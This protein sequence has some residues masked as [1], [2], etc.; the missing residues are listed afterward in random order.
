MTTALI[1]TGKE[2]NLEETF[3]KYESE[4]CADRL[5]MALADVAKVRAHTPKVAICLRV[6]RDPFPKEEMCVSQLVH[7]TLTE[8]SNSTD[9]EAFTNVITSFK[10]SDIKILIS[11]R[12]KTLFRDDA[13]DILKNVMKKFTELITDDL[14]SWIACHR[15][16]QSS[17]VQN[18]VVREESFKYLTSFATQTVLEKAL[19]ILEKNEHYKAD[20]F[21]VCCE[22]HNCFPHDLLDKLNTLLHLV[23]AGNALTKDTLAFLPLV[24]VDMFLDYIRSSTD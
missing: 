24:L 18:R 15:F 13:V 20:L 16:D 1:T 9:T 7:R 3:K 22:S 4:Q 2:G 14:P 6:A 11:I 19:T 8:I 23:K 21:C 12:Y 10:P 5:S 17:S